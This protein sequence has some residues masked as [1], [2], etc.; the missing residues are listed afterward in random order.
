MQNYLTQQ[1]SYCGIVY[2]KKPTNG[3][4]GITHGCCTVCYDEQ[5]KKI[6]AMNELYKE[7]NIQ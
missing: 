5:M 4:S 2:G 7:T 1:C 6:E 3:K